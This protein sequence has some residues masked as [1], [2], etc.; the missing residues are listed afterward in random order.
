M[1]AEA[2]KPEPVSQRLR[3]L[4]RNPI[5]MAGTALAVVSIA[6]IFLFFLIDLIAERSSPYIGILAYM[7]APGFLV[8]GLALIA[9]GAWRQRKKLVA[10]GP[11]ESMP[12]PRIDLNDPG[13]RSAVISFVGFL[14]V[15]V[16]LSAAGSYKAFEYTESVQFCG[17][18]CHTVMHP[19]YTAY[20]LSPHARVTCVECH[21][22]S[23]ASWYV[24]SKL[25]GA[26]QVFA[27]AFNTFPRPIPTPVHNLRPAQDTCEQCHWPKKFYGAQLKVFTHYSSDEKN[28]PRQIRMLIKTGGGD[29]ATG[30][31]EGIHWHMN[32]ANEIDYVATDE[33]RQVIPYIYVKDMQGRV[34]EYFS[35]DPNLNKE[36]VV[37]QARR[38]MDC[39]DCHN[40]PTHIYIPPDLAVDQSLLARRLDASLPFIKQ[41]AVTALTGDYQTTEGAVQKIAE[42]IPAFYESKYPE[43]AKSKQLEIRNAVEEVQ[44]IFRRTTFPEMKLNW[45]THPN[46]LGHFYF[47]GCFRCHDGQHVSAQGKVI[48]KECNICH[49]LMGQEEGGVSVA[50]APKIN[51]QHP[52]DLGDMTQVNCSDCHSGGNG[53]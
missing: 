39:V 31:P 29:P 50:A 30:A 45:Q 26:R 4:L 53:P 23:G 16:T 15:F 36:Q 27:A 51:F 48:S 18:T 13:Q 40:R 43:I 11:E 17:Q 1:S 52:V 28:T 8:C 37:K 35:Q 19:E 46:N 47:N 2:E 49:T 7:I 33:K 12:Y 3:R 6:N 24:K 41:Q 22:G 20:Q 25:S 42:S 21:V 34:T 9:F 5:S 44:Q 32:I 10:G 14:I 38:R